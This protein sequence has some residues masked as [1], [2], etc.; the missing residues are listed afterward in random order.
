MTF[1]AFPLMILHDMGPMDAV[2]ESAR[3]FKKTWGERAI[4]HVG[5]GFFF[6]VLIV[7]VIVSSI[8]VMWFVNPIFGISYLVIALI[9][10]IILSMLVDVIVTTLLLHY[11]NSESLPESESERML[12][13]SVAKERPAL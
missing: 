1:F 10:L 11:V 9:V 12:F 4:L 2:K 13:A 6:M 3:L 8:F 5:T 7:L